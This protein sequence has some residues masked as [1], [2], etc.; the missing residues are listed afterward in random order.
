VIGMT[1]YRYTFWRKDGEYPQGKTF[2]FYTER[3]LQW[4]YTLFRECL[5]NYRIPIDE[6]NTEFR[7][8]TVNDV[9]WILKIGHCNVNKLVFDSYNKTRQRLLDN[10][11]QPDVPPWI[12]KDDIDNQ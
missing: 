3:G 6:L 10:G 4:S 12:I 9:Y 5:R 11:I 2:S 8:V 1:L 7:V